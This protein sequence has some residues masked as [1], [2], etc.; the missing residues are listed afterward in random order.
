MPSARLAGLFF[1][2]SGAV[3]GQW[4]YLQ[5]SGVPKTP[6]EK[7][8]LAAPPPRNAAGKPDLSGMWMTPQGVRTCANG[9][10]EVNIPGPENSNFGVSLPGGLPYTTWAADLMKSRAP[11]R[12][13]D[14]PHVNCLPPT[15]PRAWTLPHIA[16]I[17]ESPLEIAILDEFNASYRQI[18]TDGRALPVDPQ[19]TWNGYS[20]GQWDGDTFVVQTIGFRDDIWLDTRGSPLTEASRVTERIRRPNFGTLDIEVT[21]ADSKAYTKPWT[22]HMKQNIVLNTEMM[23]E[24]CLENERSRRHLPGAQR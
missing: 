8:N 4:V 9:C 1:I 7:P 18:Y 24:V 19:P 12:A 13:K 10:D 3:N 21:V 17:I 22:V 6:D 5:T 2:L 15:F 20:I 23:D 16:K 14:D 11:T